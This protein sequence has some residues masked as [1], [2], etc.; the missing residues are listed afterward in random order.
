[1][2]RLGAVVVLSLALAVVIGACG[3]AGFGAEPKPTLAPTS[4]E[5]TFIRIA[6]TPHT[7]E[8]PIPTVPPT[9]TREPGKKDSSEPVFPDELDPELTDVRPDDEAIFAGWTEYLNNTSASYEGDPT[10]W[11]M[12][13]GGVVLNDAGVDQIRQNWRVER[14]PA[15][16]RQDWGTVSV[17]VDIISGRW[18]GRQFPLLTL[19]R[20][21]GK[22]M[23]ISTNNPGEVEIKRSKPCLAL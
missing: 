3:D 6:V 17:M 10:S 18:E 5:P 23:R 11:H 13:M 4:V 21:L 12:C 15:I 9:P 20:R 16:S 14:S 7:T 8:T 2:R 22:I 19:T 1:M